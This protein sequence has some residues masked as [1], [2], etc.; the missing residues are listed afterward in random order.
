MFPRCKLQ[1]GI[2]QPILQ[3]FGHICVRFEMF[4]EH[5]SRDDPDPGRAAVEI[6]A[7]LRPACPPVHVAVPE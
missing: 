7:L 4:S 5:P 1:C 3:L 2:T 6:C